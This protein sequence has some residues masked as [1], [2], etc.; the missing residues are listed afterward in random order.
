[1]K[2][3]LLFGLGGV[4]LGSALAIYFSHSW[5]RKQDVLACTTEFNFT[6]NQGKTSE[7][8]VNTVAQ[9]YFHRNG[10]GV[11]TYKGATSSRGQPMMID[12]DVNFVWKP[13][14]D[15]GAMTL[16]YTQTTRRHNDNTPDG[17]WGSFAQSG[18]RYYLTISQVAPAVWLI[19]D[20]FYP[21]YI[22]RGE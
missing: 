12:R 15:A 7:V 22:C 6:R 16:T 3:K 2:I 18:A 13:L 20:R 4:V 10:T 1:M 21:T 19:Q 14:S 11:T 8:R 5:S 9:F 17:V